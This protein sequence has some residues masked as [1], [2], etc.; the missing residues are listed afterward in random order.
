MKLSLLKLHDKGVKKNST[1]SE[2]SQNVIE[3][4]WKQRQRPEHTNT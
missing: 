2:Q 4:S 3:K 1:L